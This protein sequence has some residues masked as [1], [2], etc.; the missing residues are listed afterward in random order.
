MATTRWRIWLRS[1]I[2]TNPIESVPPL[3][4]I[5]YTNDPTPDQY[6][7]TGSSKWNILTRE[8]D[9]YSVLLSTLF[10]G[11][12]IISEFRKFVERNRYYNRWH[13]L[14]N[15]PGAGSPNKMITFEDLLSRK[16]NVYIICMLK[17]TLAHSVERNFSLMLAKLGWV[18]DPGIQ[19]YSFRSESV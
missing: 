4:A 9:R 5:K 17:F 1:K 8:Y 10:V 2:A 11:I 12:I 13:F 19:L 18:V 6:F 15:G 14:K 7:H 3:R 16:C